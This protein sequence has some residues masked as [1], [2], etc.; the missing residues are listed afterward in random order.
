MISS[1]YHYMGSEVTSSDVDEL[2][3]YL[4]ETMRYLYQLQSAVDPVW[5]EANQPDFSN[6]YEESEVDPAID[7]DAVFASIESQFSRW[8]SSFYNV[9]VYMIC[10]L[11][12]FLV[13]TINPD[14]QLL[15]IIMMVCLPFYAWG[16]FFYAIPEIKIESA[17]QE[18]IIFSRNYLTF[19][20]QITL[21]RFMF[22][23]F[24]RQIVKN[25]PVGMIFI[26][27]FT[28]LLLGVGLQ[29]LLT[30]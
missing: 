18:R 14:F 9:V 24:V 30:N 26:A 16:L 8:L 15:P 3:S 12:A 1:L 17:G 25:S 10:N 27:V 21:A 29:E 2:L 7:S 13:A 20:K 23:Y 6:Y 19:R 22:S 28:T 11:I 5:A 4:K